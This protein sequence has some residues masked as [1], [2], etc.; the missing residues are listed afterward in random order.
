LHDKHNGSVAPEV[1]NSPHLMAHQPS[2]LRNSALTSGDSKHG[3][4]SW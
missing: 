4:C 3:S 2:T 1:T